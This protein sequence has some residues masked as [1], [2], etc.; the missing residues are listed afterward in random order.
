[1][2][3]EDRS[4]LDRWVISRLNQVITDVSEAYDHYD[5]TLATRQIQ[6]FLND[7]FS[8]WYIRRSRRRYWKENSTPTNSVYSTTYEVLLALVKLSAPIAPYITRR[9]IAA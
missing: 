9:S 2:P 7:E 8:N 4:E 5:L 1:M 3:L 6:D